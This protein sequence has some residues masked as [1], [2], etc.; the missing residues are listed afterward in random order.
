M[1]RKVGQ[2]SNQLTPSIGIIADVCA[3][4]A[5]KAHE[6]NFENSSGSLNFERE[7]AD[8]NAQS[9]IRA[10]DMNSGNKATQPRDPRN[11]RPRQLERWH[12][13]ATVMFQGRT[14]LKR[15]ICFL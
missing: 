14:E 10:E 5:N 9:L 8:D 11:S 1:Y 6:A 15:D 2:I 12:L 3:G 7:T 4:D 13:R